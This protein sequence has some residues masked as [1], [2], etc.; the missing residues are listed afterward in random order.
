MNLVK[1]KYRTIITDHHLKKSVDSCYFIRESQ[2]WKTSEHE[3]Y[4]KDL[5][6]KPGVFH[7]NAS[8]I[9]HF[10]IIFVKQ[11]MFLL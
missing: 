6:I 11:F 1:S 7:V 2:H 8:L 3:G 9:R 4:Q 5:R 10:W